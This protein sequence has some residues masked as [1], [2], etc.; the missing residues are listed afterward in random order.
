MSVRIRKIFFW[1]GLGIVLFTNAPSTSAFNADLDINSAVT[2]NLNLLIQ[3]GFEDFSEEIGLAVSYLPLSPAEPLGILGF[4]IG[5]EVTA[6]DIKQDS[7]Y[8]KVIAPGAPSQIP[9]PKI[10]VQKGLPFGIDV[11]AV[12]A[13]VPNSNIEMAGG[14]IKWAFIKGN[15]LLPSIAVRASYTR[16][17]G[18]NNLD[19]ETAGADISISKG[20]LFLTPYIGYGQVWIKS[21]IVDLPAPLNLES[22]TTLPKPFV[23][24]KISPLPIINIV[25][26]ADFSKITLY[27]LR[28]N[29]GF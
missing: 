5:V 13:R 23:G 3:G 24:V 27:T 7:P 15:T 10:H 25:A 8:W 28:F 11:S 26:E 20:F 2:N 16:L 14:A 29:V 4:D 9:L 12:Y 19:L 21:K 6:V 18:V 22:N 1:A 17:L